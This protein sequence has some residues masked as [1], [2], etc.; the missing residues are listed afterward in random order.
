MQVSAIKK[1]KFNDPFNDFLNV[2]YATCPDGY[3]AYDFIPANSSFSFNTFADTICTQSKNDVCPTLNKNPSTL[4]F[5]DKKPLNIWYDTTQGNDYRSN[6]QFKYK[7][8]NSTPVNC[9]YPLTSFQTFGDVVN[10]QNNFEAFPSAEEKAF[11]QETLNNDILPY[12]CSIQSLDCPLDPLRPGESV[13]Q[14]RCSRFTSIDPEGD[15]CRQWAAEFPN[16]ADQVKVQFCHQSENLHASECACINKAYDPL[17]RTAKKSVEVPDFCWWTPCANASQ[18]L[19][20]ASEE[21]VTECPDVCGII[22]NNYTNATEID[23]SKAN[24]YIDCTKGVEPPKSNKTAPESSIQILNTLEG[25]VKKYPLP[26][27]L[28]PFQLPWEYWFLFSIMIVLV[29]VY[30]VFLLIGNKY[31]F[32]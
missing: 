32:V 31:L 8:Y 14:T 19:I 26:I 25:N 2:G 15:I 30:I 28:D 22:I 20:P 23:L 18:F 4:N 24:I 11:A 12:F 7:N 16:L 9:S 29:I 3:W 27:Y 13:T 21:Q 5:F 10:Y 1:Q 17:Y 6:I